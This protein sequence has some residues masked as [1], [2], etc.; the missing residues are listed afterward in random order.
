MVGQ[1]SAKTIQMTHK[2]H[3]I[4][5]E[6]AQQSTFSPFHRQ[7]TLQSQAS[8]PPIPVEAPAR[9][10]HLLLQYQ[11]HQNNQRC[12]GGPD[13]KSSISIYEN[14][15][16]LRLTLSQFLKDERELQKLI[17]PYNFS[18]PRIPMTCQPNPLCLKA[19]WSQN[20]SPF[21]RFFQDQRQ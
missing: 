5:K 16:V 11:R 15:L 3:I 10:I 14:I 1:L 9:K 6:L 7:I 8:Q 21:F 17:Q 4:F 2:N 19:S 13:N 20:L 18:S 12:S